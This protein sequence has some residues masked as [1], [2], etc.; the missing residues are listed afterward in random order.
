MDLVYM[1]YSGYGYDMFMGSASLL[2][3]LARDCLLTRTTIYSESRQIY[4][5]LRSKVREKGRS[6]LLFLSWL[7]QA[8]TVT[9]SSLARLPGEVGLSGQ[10]GRAWQDVDWPRLR[11]YKSEYSLHKIRTSGEE[12]QRHLERT[13]TLLLAV[14]LCVDIQRSSYL[15][16]SSYNWWCRTL[17]WVCDIWLII[18]VILINCNM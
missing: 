14:V 16:R 6:R 8:H 5:V 13:R 18:V 2:G 1:Y 3:L 12:H 17:L 9:A 4:E 7:G 10:G 15:M 11:V